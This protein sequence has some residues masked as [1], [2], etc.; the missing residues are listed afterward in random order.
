MS[1]PRNEKDEDQFDDLRLEN[2]IKKIKIALEHG[3][4]FLS[5]IDEDLPPELEREWLDYIQQFEEELAKRKKILV[6]SLIGRPHYRQST[7]IPDSEIT[8]ELHKIRDI[9][10][11]NAITVD[12]I[13]PVPDRELYRFI[14][15]ELFQEVTNDL[16]I[17]G[18][19]TCFIYEEYHP[20][21]DYDI[22]SRCTEF[23]NH[24]LDKKREW[25]PDYLGLA[26]VV[27]T[28]KGELTN[29]E[30]V[31]KIILF[32]D[33]FSRLTILDFIITSV[34][35]SENSAEAQCEIRYTATVEGTDE[36]M[37]FSGDTNFGLSYTSKLWVISR[38]SLPGLPL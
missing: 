8:E 12:T 25:A 29:K 37:T 24:V 19:T 30:V 9:L 4:H 36:E 33:S 16:H 38:L 22:R 31:E 14:T 5:P 3:G 17:E 34:A 2:E 21:H 32:R 15:D 7:T 35:I 23:V 20:N 10:H 13:C 6:Y 26:K 18:M 28:S 1:E 11:R 27:K